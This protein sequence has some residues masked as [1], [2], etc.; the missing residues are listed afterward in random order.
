MSR[1]QDDHANRKNGSRSNAHELYLSNHNSSN[2]VNADDEDI[3]DEPLLRVDSNNNVVAVKHFDGD[4]NSDQESID[5]NLLKNFPKP[6][7]QL[8]ETDSDSRYSDA[9]T[10]KGS[11]SFKPGQVPKIVNLQPDPNENNEGLGR[12]TSVKVRKDS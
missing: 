10:Q 1:S 4:S 7:Y 6:R 2:T 11:F 5:I 12:S 8:K 9:Y 3:S